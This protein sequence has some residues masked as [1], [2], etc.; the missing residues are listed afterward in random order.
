MASLSN[1]R[2]GAAV[3]APIAAAPV[4]D[5][6]AVAVAP[7]AAI[8]DGVTLIDDRTA[9][10]V[11]SRGRVIKIK[12]LSALDRMRLFK[13]VG[14]EDSENRLFMSYASA[15]AAVTE[16]EGLAVTPVAN[17][18]QLSA[19]VARLDE[20]GLEAVVNGLVALNPERED[21]ATA[22]KNS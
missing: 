18:I 20:H 19:L 7:V 14:A 8:P 4:S 3:A 9:S 15:A 2:S 13:A 12:K 21:V 1:V 10:V 6:P 22:A 5:S 16:L 11:D 17:Q